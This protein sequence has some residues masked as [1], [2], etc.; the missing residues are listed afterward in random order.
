MGSKPVV[1]LPFI[2]HHLKSA[3]PE[4]EQ[5]QPN[6]IDP[7]GF[8]LFLL[9]VRGIGD[10][11]IGQQQRNDSHRNI[12]EEN[13]APVEIVGNPSAQRRTDGR[14]Q[15]HG[16]AVN[17]ESHAAPSRFERVSE[18]G[19]F[20]G[21]QTTAAGTLQNTADDQGSEIRSEYRTGTN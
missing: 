9:H 7:E 3:Q 20:A 1:P 13:P 14:S 8:I 5:S 17:R 16:H 2:Q 18:D 21:L 10:Q 6:E 19:L 15:H 4:R 11:Q 12:D